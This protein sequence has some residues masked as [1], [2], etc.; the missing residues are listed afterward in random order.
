[1]QLYEKYWKI[2]LEYSDFN[3]KLFNECLQIIVDF[4]DNNDTSIYTKELYKELQSQVYRFNPKCDFAS[5][6]KSINQFL[7]LGFINNHFTS[8]HTKTKDF[9]WKAKRSTKQIAS[10]LSFLQKENTCKK[11]KNIL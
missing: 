3:S 2:T 4:I 8:Y 10:A 5:V 7:K 11:G 9:F 1:M 6:R